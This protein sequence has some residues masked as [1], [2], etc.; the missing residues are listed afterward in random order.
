MK[1]RKIL[2]LVGAEGTSNF[3]HDKYD[4]YIVEPF[5]TTQDIS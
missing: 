4:I 5:A 3:Y 1:N 2:C